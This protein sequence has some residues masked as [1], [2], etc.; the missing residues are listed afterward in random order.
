MSSGLGGILHFVTP[1]PHFS[2]KCECVA[3]ICGAER[4]EGAHLAHRGHLA[5]SAGLFLVA[6]P[7]G[8]QA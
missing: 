6:P 3:K 7:L 5:V 4:R 8:R 2:P 1:D